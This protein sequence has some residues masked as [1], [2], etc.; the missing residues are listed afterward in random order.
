LHPTSASIQA[1]TQLSE[2]S[3]KAHIFARNALAKPRVEAGKHLW[4]AKNIKKYF[5][6][7]S[8][9]LRLVN[10]WHHLT[11]RCGP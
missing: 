2:L 3:L 7:N 11:I 9:S 4:D 8:A 6:P 5:G 10:Q 1:Q